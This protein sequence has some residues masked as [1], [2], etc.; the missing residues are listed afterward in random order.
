MGDN[1]DFRKMI[2]HAIKTDLNDSNEIFNCLALHAIAN[3]GGKE[4]STSLAEEIYKQFISKYRDLLLNFRSRS[5]FVKTKAGLCLLRIFR[6]HPEIIPAKEWAQSLVQVM[7]DTDLGVVHA[8][9]C[10]VTALAQIHPEAYSESATKAIMK[11]SL[12]V[13]GGEFD[14]NYAYY[15]VPAPWLQVR[16]LRLL[17]YFPAR[18]QTLNNSSIPRNN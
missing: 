16:L 13:V 8:A 17:Q 11:L 7:D 2:V 4:L 9:T 3:I 15:K 5:P 18:K 12:I 1:Q 10:L 6:K 14:V